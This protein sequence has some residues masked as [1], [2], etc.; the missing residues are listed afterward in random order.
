MKKIIII[1]LLVLTTMLTGFSQC[2]I[3]KYADLRLRIVMKIPSYRFS[4]GEISTL[5]KEF[6]VR[7][8][9]FCTFVKQRID[10]IELHPKQIEEYFPDVRQ[11]IT[12]VSDEGSDTLFSDGARMEK[13]GKCLVFDEILQEVINKAIEDYEQTLPKTIRGLGEEFQMDSLPSK[14]HKKGSVPHGRK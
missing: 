2:V 7:D 9:I 14:R 13:S 1:F 6:E 10:S 5:T 12:I 4:I 3:I 11:Q 8:S